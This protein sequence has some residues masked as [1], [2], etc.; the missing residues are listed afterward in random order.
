MSVVHLNNYK[1]RKF[2]QG[3]NFVLNCENPQIHVKFFLKEMFYRDV[4]SE[5]FDLLYDNT[6]RTKIV[7]I[8]KRRKKNKTEQDYLASEL[9]SLQPYSLRPNSVTGTQ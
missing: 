9:P 8:L 6:F 2:L 3:R 4:K 7:V 1:I 5:V